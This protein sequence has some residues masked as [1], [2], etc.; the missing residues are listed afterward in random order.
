MSRDQSIKADAGKPRPTLVPPEA[1]WAIAEVRGYGSA[2][3]G[4][5]DADFKLDQEY[6]RIMGKEYLSEADVPVN[7]P[8]EPVEAKRT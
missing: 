8:I 2:K 4:G 3:D 6:K 5:A 1:I 7:S